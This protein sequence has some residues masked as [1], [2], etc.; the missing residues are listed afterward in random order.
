MDIQ[1]FGQVDPFFDGE[2]GRS[3]GHAFIFRVGVVLIQ[4]ITHVG[5]QGVKS[6]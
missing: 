2:E 6:T 5:G 4:Q 3:S 1:L